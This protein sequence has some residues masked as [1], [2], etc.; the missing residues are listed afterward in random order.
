MLSGSYLAYLKVER[1]TLDGR[2]A[3]P[4]TAPLK[5][6]SAASGAHCR[7]RNASIAFAQPSFGASRNFYP[8]L[9]GALSRYALVLLRNRM[10]C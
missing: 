7:D 10:A 5:H 9:D 3:R 6:T 4:R 2:A 1:V 8:L